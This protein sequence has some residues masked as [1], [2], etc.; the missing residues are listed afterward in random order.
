MAITKVQDV[1]A[2]GNAASATTLVLTISGIT[3]TVGNHLVCR[4]VHSGG[5]LTGITDSKGNTWQIDEDG[6]AS[7]TSSGSM[8]STKLTSALVN[9]DTITLT[10]FATSRAAATVEEFSGLATTS[11]YDVGSIAA[12]AASTSADSG[13]TATSAVADS[14]IIGNLAY[15]GTITS[16]T[17]ESLSPA[18]VLDQQVASTGTVRAVQGT[19]RIV[20][21]TGTFAFKATW[22]TSRQHNSL[23]GVYKGAGSGTQNLTPAII[24]QTAATF[25]PTVTTL[26]T[27]VPG[28]ITQTAATFSPVITQAAS[29]TP[30]LITNTPTMFS[31]T[32]T[33]G[34]VF[35]TP[36]LIDRTPVM[37]TPSLTGFQEINPALIDR[38]PVIFA[39]T[40][41]T[42]TAITP[43][44]INQTASM[45]PPLVDLGAPPFVPGV[46]RNLTGGVEYVI[47][48]FNS[49]ATFGPNTKLGE[50]WD[51]RNV[52]WSRYDRLPGK[53]FFTLPQTSP[54]LASITPLLTHV[55]I[56]RCTIAADTLIYRGVAY[57][58]D[59]TGDDVIVECFDYLALLS[60]SRAGFKTLYPTKA[61]GS[62]IVSPQWT[63]AKN[64]TGS[65]LGFVTTGT[66]QDPLGTDAV[67]VIKTNAQFGTLD[68]MRLQLFYDLSEMGRA[69]T[70]NQTTFEIDLTNTFNFWK[71]QGSTSG[72]GLILNGNVSDYRYLPNWKRYRND[73]AT[74]GVA[75]TGGPSEIVSTNTS[76]ITA[77]ALRQDVTTLKTL[78]GI[79]GGLTNAD[80]QKA[81]LEHA[82]RQLYQQ[83]STLALT[84]VRGSFDPA[85]T[86][87]NNIHP[88]ELVNGND[89]ITGT[90]RLLGMRG[91]YR[92]SGEDISAVIGVVAS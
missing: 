58:T 50:V 71:N 10:F 24:T 5:V 69:N 87:I 35:I 56:Y 4:A 36:G 91:F 82:L 9:A 20:S 59:S 12:E 67:T 79:A 78:A 47:E 41:T 15:V 48:L 72:I 26:T 37:H 19:H 68:Q 33:T 65:P 18:W 52:G 39:P 66:I 77:R 53:G 1:V 70:I 2:A 13:L 88:V 90:R 73:L 54:L 21:A 61:L 38:T 63:L 6:T 55:A 60:I 44:L 42:F 8:A 3:T 14:L 11:W 31:P 22:T 75:A 62:E 28:L 92:E 74:L 40:V 29:I 30:A 83:P 64:A 43:G 45:F 57:D 34:V 25:S 85:A 86:A 84:L 7:D 27:I 17:P 46:P 76:E 51:A 49:G 89:T 80:Q 32:V 23:V 81:A 16:F